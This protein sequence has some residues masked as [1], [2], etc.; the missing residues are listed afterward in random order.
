M[1]SLGFM[2]IGE[3]QNGHRESSAG[4]SRVYF[5]TGRPSPSR[6]LLVSDGRQALRRPFS[7]GSGALAY[8]RNERLRGGKLTIVGDS[9]IS[10]IREKW[11]MPPSRKVRA[12]ACAA[13]LQPRITSPYDSLAA[14]NTLSATPLW[15]PR[16]CRRT[17]RPLAGGS[18]VMVPRSHAIRMPGVQMPTG[19]AEQP[20]LPGRSDRQSWTAT[21]CNDCP[22]LSRLAELEAL[23]DPVGSA[24]LLA[25]AC[26]R[27]TVS[28][29]GAGLLV[30]SGF[31]PGRSRLGRRVRASA[32]ACRCGRRAVAILA[33]SRGRCARARPGLRISRAESIRLEPPSVP[34]P[35][36]ARPGERLPPL[37]RCYWPEFSS[38]ITPFCAHF[39]S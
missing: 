8:T 3:S 4:L 16:Q 7:A 1:F 27:P 21:I 13:Y 17:V 30:W 2:A 38:G 10:S 26:P 9:P 12:I 39:A 31:L 29:A 14:P 19:V 15:F 6:P 34:V 22:E 35:G 33:I 28:R 24:A 32:G 36:V 23:Q 37:R 20:R 25:A 18:S 11:L 5:R